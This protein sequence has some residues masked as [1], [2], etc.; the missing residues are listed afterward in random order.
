MTLV[1]NSLIS[2]F[3]PQKLYGFHFSASSEKL[4][5][6]VEELKEL[7]DDFDDFSLVLSFLLALVLVQLI[8]RFYI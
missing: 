7:S 5:K 8:A 6:Y 1:A 2:D 4:M 3:D